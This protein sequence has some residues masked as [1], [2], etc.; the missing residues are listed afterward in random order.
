MAKSSLGVL[1]I[2][3]AVFIVA[4]SSDAANWK[5]VAVAPSGTI[6]ELDTDSVGR[7]GPDLVHRPDNRRERKPSDVFGLQGELW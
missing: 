3:L 6:V 2:I 1:A 5:R 4:Q 7:I